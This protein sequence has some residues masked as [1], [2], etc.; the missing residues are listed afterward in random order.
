M[1]ARIGI[2]VSGGGTACSYLPF[3][4][5]IVCVDVCLIGVAS[6]EMYTISYLQG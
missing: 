4:S 1:I 6:M 3:S 5:A 2:F